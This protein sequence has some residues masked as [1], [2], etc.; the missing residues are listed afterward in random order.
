LLTAAQMRAVR[1]LAGMEQKTLAT[2]ARKKPRAK[3]YH[4]ARLSLFASW[5]R[6]RRTRTPTAMG[7]E[8]VFTRQ[9]LFP[10]QVV[11]VAGLL[12]G[13]HPATHGDDKNRPEA[14]VATFGHY[15]QRG[16]AILTMSSGF[17][18]SAVQDEAGTKSTWSLI[19]S[20]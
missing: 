3:I 2:S 4:L 7:L 10:R 15:L 20:V 17:A 11:D 9:E 5:G 1:A 6:Q 16:G 18:L 12:D 19:P 14:P 13:D 8:S